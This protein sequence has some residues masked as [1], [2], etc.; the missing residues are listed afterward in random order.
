MLFEQDVLRRVIFT[1]PGALRFDTEPSGPCAES[2]RSLTMAVLITSC[3]GNSTAQRGAV[4][5]APGRPGVPR[6]S[7]H[8]EPHRLA[9]PVTDLQRGSVEPATAQNAGSRT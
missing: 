4:S 2:P 1:K 8:R 6:G 5:G 7:G 3:A 9:H